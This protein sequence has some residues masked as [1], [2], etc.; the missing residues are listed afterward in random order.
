MLTALA[1]SARELAGLDRSPKAKVSTFIGKELPSET[2]RKL[3]EFEGSTGNT[4]SIDQTVYQVTSSALADFSNNDATPQASYFP[5]KNQ[6]SGENSK[7]LTPQA[8]RNNFTSIAESCFVMPLVNR[9]WLAL[10]HTG[11]QEGLFIPLLLA[12]FFGTLSI[13][14]HASASTSSLAN[15]LAEVTKLAL[16]L[17]GS[18]DD[19]AEVLASQ[20]ELLLVSFQAATSRPS[21]Q[22]QLM[23]HFDSRETVFRSKAWAE[24]VWTVEENRGGDLSRLGRSAAGL[25]LITEKLC[26]M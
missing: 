3:V 6:L 22:N 26:Q 19:D 7:K 12:R 10:H 9:M 11:S 25:V 15:M 18:M 21:V 1:L 16:A 8:I 20:L 5:Q 13:L 17:R 4:D 2:R 24:D 23:R 14:V